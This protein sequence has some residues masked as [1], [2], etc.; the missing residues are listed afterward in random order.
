MSCPF[1]G[2]IPC[3]AACMVKHGCCEEPGD[4]AMPG[5]PA[6]DDSYLA[7]HKQASDAEAGVP[8]GLAYLEQSL[9]GK[10]Q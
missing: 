1:N 6:D 2:E 8:G 10:A 7:A 9:Y 4:M 5:S 3:T